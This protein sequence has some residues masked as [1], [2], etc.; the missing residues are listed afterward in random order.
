MYSEDIQI[1]KHIDAHQESKQNFAFVLCRFNTM[2]E[3]VI[4][5]LMI[6]TRASWKVLIVYVANSITSIRVTCI[7]PQ[8]V[9][10]PRLGQY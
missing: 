1:A 6:L 8:Y 5:I 2:P 3:Y 7:M 10:V 4:K 9:S